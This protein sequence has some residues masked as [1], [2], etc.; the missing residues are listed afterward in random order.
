MDYLTIKVCYDYDEGYPNLIKEL[1]E[2]YK[3]HGL[4]FLCTDEPDETYEYACEQ[5][6]YCYD[7][8][9]SHDD[10]EHINM[11]WDCNWLPANTVWTM[12]V[13]EVVKITDYAVYT[14]NKEEWVLFPEYE[15]LKDNDKLD[16]VFELSKD[17]FRIKGVHEVKIQNEYC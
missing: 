11:Y 17:L 6:Q 9:I 14:K 15:V 1:H 4:T 2:V 12:P 7:S 3:K 16:K 10:L 13:I 8:R 5:N